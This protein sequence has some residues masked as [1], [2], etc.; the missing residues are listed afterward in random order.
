MATKR[1]VITGVSRGLGRAMLSGFASRGHRLFGC[2]TNAEAIDTLVSEYPSPHAME[3]V[4][5]SSDDQVASW[6]QRVL[7]DGPPDLLINNAAA[8][9][10][11]DVLWNVASAEF[12]TLMNVNVTGTFHVIRHFV[13]AMIAAGSGVIVNFSS[14]WGRSTSPEVTPYCATKWAIEGLTRGL[15]QELPRGLAAVALNPGIIH[16]DMLDVCFGAMAKS[17]PSPTQWAEH[18][19]PFL[20]DLDA[21]DNGQ[22][23]N[24]PG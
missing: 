6:A 12:A 22:S 19:V 11:K 10:T 14:G 13:P 1:I 5:V 15:A 16:T 2:A 9:N 7:A 23:L 21:S 4:D 20:L 17:F 3:V 8:M 18:A 24:V